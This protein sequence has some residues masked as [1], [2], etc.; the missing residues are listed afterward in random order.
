MHAYLNI[1]AFPGFQGLVEYN[2]TACV[3]FFLYVSMYLIYGQFNI[4][5]IFYNWFIHSAIDEHLS[6]F[7]L[8]QLKEKL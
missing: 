2:H 8:F 1:I 3:L 6:G 7:Q 4:I 5:W